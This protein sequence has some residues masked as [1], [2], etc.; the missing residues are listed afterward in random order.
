MDA[1]LSNSRPKSTKSSCKGVVYQILKEELKEPGPY[2]DLFYVVWCL[3]LGQTYLG[4]K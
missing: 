1:F 3:L 4:Q 2:E